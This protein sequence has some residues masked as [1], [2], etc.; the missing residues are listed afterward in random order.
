LD[1]FSLNG[2]LFISTWAITES[3]K[4]S[5]DYVIKLNWF[6]CNH[7]LLNYYSKSTEFP[8]YLIHKIEKDKEF[9]IEN[10]DFLPDN[11]YAF[12]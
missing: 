9:I 8:N 2:D 1:K 12:L 5:Q 10:I 7:I 6:N 4:Y 11:K 3:S